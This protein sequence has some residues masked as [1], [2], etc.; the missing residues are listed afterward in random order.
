MSDKGIKVDSDLMTNND[1]IVWLRECV[2][3]CTC[4]GACLSH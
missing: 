3:V 4:V 2:C 1:N